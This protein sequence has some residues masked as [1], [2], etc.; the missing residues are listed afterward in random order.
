[1]ENHHIAG[2]AFEDGDGLVTGADDYE[3][4]DTTDE[5]GSGDPPA[6]PNNYPIPGDGS[7]GAKAQKGGSGG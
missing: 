2:T 3:P 7:T 1:M 6:G 4:P 5:P